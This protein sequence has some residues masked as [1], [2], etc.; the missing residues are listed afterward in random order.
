MKKLKLIWLLAL[1]FGVFACDEADRNGG[2]REMDPIDGDKAKAVMRNM[3]SDMKNDIVELVSSEGVQAV[4]QLVEL[5][6]MGF[7]A[8]PYT[9]YT[10]YNFWDTDYARS[11]KA[12]LKV[13]LKA[14]ALHRVNQFRTVFVPKH[15]KSA[16]TMN[17]ALSFD[18]MKGVYVYDAKSGTF[19]KVEDSEMVI[20]R[21]PSKG[22][23]VNDAEFRITAYQ[24]YV[25]QSDYGYG[26][27]TGR[28][29]TASYT[30]AI[31]SLISADLSIN[32][33]QYVSVNYSMSFVDPGIPARGS[34]S[35]FLK[36]FTYA[37]SFDI[38]SPNVAMAN[39]S[40]SRNGDV[41]FSIGAEVN[42]NGDIS[43]NP[44]F[45][46]L[47]G[48]VQYRNLK[49]EGAADVEAMHNAGEGA[50][51]N[52]H[53]DFVFTDNGRVFGKLHIEQEKRT[54]YDY[55]LEKEVEYYRT[56]LY[57]RYNNGV[58]EKLEDVLEEMLDEVEDVLVG[59]VG[60]F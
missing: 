54:Y 55:W 16:R 51:W 60:E 14:G 25:Y 46:R 8:D 48:H 50:D 5:M 29:S 42:Y 20:Y 43:G 12:P 33:E 10:D 35:L 26:W 57:I 17:S 52:K 38:S 22:S 2:V 3:G 13:K 40:L 11:K 31:P 24:E 34:F 15:L 6:D 30:Y 21:F 27:E 53:H 58:K 39:T 37:L 44:G 56:E 19:D 1:I 18:D 32:G 59:A 9:D 49:L 45:S 23:S 41:L 4:A 47:A 7:I 36:P 28:A